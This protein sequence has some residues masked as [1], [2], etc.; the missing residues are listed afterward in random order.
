MSPHET[1]GNGSERSCASPGNNPLAEKESSVKQ[2]PRGKNTER[3]EAQP[4][5]RSS[6]VDE[7]NQFFKAAIKMSGIKV[8]EYSRMKAQT[9]RA[10]NSSLRS[11][12]SWKSQ[13]DLD[14]LT[15]SS[16]KESSIRSSRASVNGESK[17]TRRSFMQKQK[18]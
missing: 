7:Y 12:A 4:V 1:D 3:A 9:H 17:T 16:K 15:K 10:T 5:K 14:P 2:S 18:K 8:Q 6:A 11:D 13:G